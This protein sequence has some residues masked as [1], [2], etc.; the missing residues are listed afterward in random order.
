ILDLL[1]IGGG[2][3]GAGVARDAAMW[4]L[5]VALVDKADFAAGTSSRSSK[6][7]HGGLRYLEQLAFGLVAE[8][9]RERRILR[10]TAPHLVRPLP[11]LLP[12]YDGDR[13]PLPLMRLGMALYD[14]LA[15]YGNVSPHR[16]L[17][18]LDVTEAEP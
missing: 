12:V 13:R 11:F 17:D 16:G 9:C 3:L 18:P 1:V 8:A 14:L 4:G 10:E 5:R 6:L 2:M 15:R 7:I